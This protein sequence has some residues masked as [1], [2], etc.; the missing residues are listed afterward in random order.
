MLANIHIDMID[1]RGVS[2]S[3]TL[4]AEARDAH[5]VNDIVLSEL[6]RLVRDGYTHLRARRTILQSN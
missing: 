4:N 1:E 3:K 2:D 5:G 6:E